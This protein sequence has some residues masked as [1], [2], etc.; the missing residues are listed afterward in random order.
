VYDALAKELGSD[1]EKW[2]DTFSWI[3]WRLHP[4][5]AVP[6]LQKRLLNPDLAP[7][8]RS[9]ALTALA[10]IP[11][12][13]A[14][15]AMIEVASKNQAAREEALGWLLSRRGNDWKEF[16]VAEGLKASGVYDP[17]TVQLAA[18]EFPPIPEDAPKLPPTEEILKLSADAARGQAAF[19][20]C[21][22]CHQ[23]GGTGPDYGPDL[24]AFG[25]QQPREVI[26]NAIL[27]PSAD[28]S[29]GYDGME[30]K[31]KDGLTI[32]GMVVANGDPVVMKCV[33]GV[34]QRVPKSRVASLRPLGRSL[35]YEPSQL[36]LDAQK[37]ADI[38]AYLKSIPV[39]H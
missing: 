24:T 36:G 17:D 1:P 4:P 21:L 22:S 14:A 38:V 6:A 11:T 12:R 27:N 35:M 23:V 9:L 29:H 28:I 25:G 3:A 26:I 32:I 31:T 19:G 5:Q 20:A 13:E 30:L 10:F 34:V 33:G 7:A 16:E 8:Q 18:V 39:P 37:V 2:S 15:A